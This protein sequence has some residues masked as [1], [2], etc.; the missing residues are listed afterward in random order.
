MSSTTAILARLIVGETAENDTTL[1][2]IGTSTASRIL[3]RLNLTPDQAAALMNG[4]TTV[5]TDQHAAAPDSAPSDRPTPAPETDD[6]GPDI[7]DRIFH[8]VIHVA[9][10]SLPVPAIDFDLFRRLL[11][12]ADGNAFFGPYTGPKTAVDEPTGET[13]FD[14]GDEADSDDLSVQYRKDAETIL[15]FFAAIGIGPVTLIHALLADSPRRYD[16]K[17]G[18]FLPAADRANAALT[19]L[20]SA[21]SKDI[22]Q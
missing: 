6:H 12:C 13:F 20:I 8:H 18:Q 22:E 9:G 2:R 14:P 17:A 3:D 1:W 19:R 21:L 10:D 11:A 4:T 15:A 7:I 16:V 5:V